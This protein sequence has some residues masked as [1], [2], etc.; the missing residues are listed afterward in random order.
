MKANPGYGKSPSAEYLAAQANQARNSPAQLASYLRLHLGIRTKQSERFITLDSWDRNAGAV[1][2]SPDQMAE[3]YRGRVCY[4]GWDLGA[5]S[6]RRLSRCSS[7]MIAA[8]M[9]C[10]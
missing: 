1:Y 9:T 5:V 10:C 8:A 7:R 3:A 6:D 4:G 2:A